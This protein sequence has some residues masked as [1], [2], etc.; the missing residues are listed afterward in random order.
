MAAHASPPSPLLMKAL[1]IKPLAVGQVVGV[2]GGG[3]GQRGA[4]TNMHFVN[5]RVIS[6]FFDK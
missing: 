6:N 1:V 4:H 5:K 2:R 3:A